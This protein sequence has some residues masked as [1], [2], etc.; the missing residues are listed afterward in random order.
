M[1]FGG[2]LHR[3]IHP[4]Q[5]PVSLYEYLIKTYTL[6]N[7]TILDFASGSSTL[8][9]ACINT[10]RKYI[11]IEKDTNYYNISKE[12]I[13]SHLLTIENSELKIEN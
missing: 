9:I 5:K 3:K 12:R 11:C 6:K 10:G 4:T 1:A 13:E 7:E 8:S 2:Y